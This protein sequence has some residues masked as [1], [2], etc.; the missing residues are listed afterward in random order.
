MELHTVHGRVGQSRLTPR[1]ATS[2]HHRESQCP[3]FDID[4]ITK[5]VAPLWA[6][7]SKLGYAVLPTGSRTAV[8]RFVVC[9]AC[10][11]LR[12]FLFIDHNIR[13]ASPIDGKVPPSLSI[14]ISVTVSDGCHRGLGIPH[15]SV[16]EQATQKG[17]CGENMIGDNYKVTFYIQLLPE[18][19][20]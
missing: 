1:C 9:S 13:I 11:A 15:R 16:V 5:R 17:D 6:A 3:L 20:Y 18:C 7:V 2:D 19:D 8:L 14:V 10:H 12:T 4:K